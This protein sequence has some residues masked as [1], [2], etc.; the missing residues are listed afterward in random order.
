M[1]NLG[2]DLM[3]NK[4]LFG[5]SNDD[6]LRLCEAFVSASDIKP[7]GLERIKTLPDKAINKIL[8]MRYKNSASKIVICDGQDVPTDVRQKFLMDMVLIEYLIDNGYDFSKESFNINLVGN[9]VI[10]DSVGL[11]DSYYHAFEVGCVNPPLIR[12]DS[13]T[14]TVETIKNNDGNELR[15]M[16]YLENIKN[17]M[18]NIINEKGTNRSL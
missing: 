11:L 14:K 5:V 9:E 18:I 12:Y 17:K 7:N 2:D 3:N 10:R 8:N 6:E 1:D 4:E 15:A 16:E 13:D